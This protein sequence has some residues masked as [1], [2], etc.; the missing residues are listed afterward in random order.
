MYN[1]SSS[2]SRHPDPCEECGS[3][4]YRVGDDGYTYCHRG[5]QQTQASATGFTKISQS[6]ADDQDSA[7][8]S[9]LKTLGSL[10]LGGGLPDGGT[11]MRSLSQ[12][13]VCAMDDGARRIP[14][15]V[16]M[17][18]SFWLSWSPCFRTLSTL[19]AIDSSETAAMAG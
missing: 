19:P 13:K 4:R 7:V 16:L 18:C 12:V 14:S 6:R 10:S 1:M 2:N 17:A 15:A 5:H 11:R 3:R 8:L 9:L